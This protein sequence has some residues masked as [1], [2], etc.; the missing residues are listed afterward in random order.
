MLIATQSNLVKAHLLVHV[1]TECNDTC[2]WSGL[3]VDW[4][5]AVRRGAT[6]I[7][8]RQAWKAPDRNCQ[9][10]PWADT[11]RAS[12]R[13]DRLMVTVSRQFRP[14]MDGLG[15]RSSPM[16]G[17]RFPLFVLANFIVTLPEQKPILAG[18]T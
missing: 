18:Q 7:K 15:D 8:K 12:A 3:S 14:G 2:D 1:P 4:P 17:Y 5:Y 13:F 10:T 9:A 16:S 6:G 11:D